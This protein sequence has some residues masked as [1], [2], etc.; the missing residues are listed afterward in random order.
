MTLYEINAALEAFE[1]EVDED[2][3][4]ILNYDKLAELNMAKDEK[5]ENIALYIKNLTAEAKAIREEEKALAERRR[6]W[7][8]MTS[9]MKARRR[10][11]DIAC[12][13]EAHKLHA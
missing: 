9:F 2:T 1:S 4:E 8:I 5:R 7:P 3:G 10:R 11:E 13:P 12:L 6:C